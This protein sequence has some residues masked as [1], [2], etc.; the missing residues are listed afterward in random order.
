MIIDPG[1]GGEDS[2]A[3]SESG[4]KEKDVVL[5][6]ALSMVAWNKGLLE[7]EYDIYLTRSKD[8]LISLED[9]TK[10]AKHLRPDLLIS[11]HVN[12]SQYGGVHGSEAYVYSKS[13]YKAQYSEVIAQEI[14][15]QLN[16]NL[17]FAVRGIK[18][19]N[20]KLLRETYGIC[21]SVLLELG[22]LSNATETEFLGY[23]SKRYVLGLAILSSL[24]LP[25]T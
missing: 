16:L 25:D 21:S 9:R 17:H 3:I 7:S 5:D 18:K 23:K 8:T 15:N 2:G 20:F 14:L 19:A 1:H 11:L 6:I 24:N 10:L 12:H 22:F 4:L 13:N